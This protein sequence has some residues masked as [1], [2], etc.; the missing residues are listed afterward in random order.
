M[1]D[2][3]SI[4]FCLLRWGDQV[5]LL[6]VRVGRDCTYAAFAPCLRGLFCP[7]LIFWSLL[8][9]V[10]ICWLVSFVTISPLEF[11]WCFGR[12]GG[13]LFAWMWVHSFWRCLLYR[14]RFR[15]AG[16]IDY[17]VYFHPFCLI[18]YTAGKLRLHR[19]QLS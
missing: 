17:F 12:V 5:F 13:A 1:F 10:R 8:V 4:Y 14:P 16:V 19:A 11:S 15:F 7:L 9:S 3:A 18:I 2:L 6:S